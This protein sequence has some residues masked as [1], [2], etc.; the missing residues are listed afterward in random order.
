MEECE[1]VMEVECGEGEEEGVETQAEKEKVKLGGNGMVSTVN[2]REISPLSPRLF[3]LSLTLPPQE[4]PSVEVPNSQ[5]AV[6]LIPADMDTQVESLGEEEKVR[7]ERREEG[8][9]GV[10][11]EG[12]GALIG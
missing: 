3:L 5:D 1:S 9:E 8:W 7:A 12:N 4:V 6:T 10:G 11:R 2:Q